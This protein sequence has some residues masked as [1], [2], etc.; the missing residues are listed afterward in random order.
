MEKKA[1]KKIIDE[2]VEGG[3]DRSLF[4]IIV[5][6]MNE[7]NDEEL[8]KLLIKNMTALAECLCVGTIDQSWRAQTFD[9]SKGRYPL[10]D[11]PEHVRELAKELYYRD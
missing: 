11:L 10:E 1:I 2:L 9:I 4:P 7:L 3:S 5:F 6:D 8:D